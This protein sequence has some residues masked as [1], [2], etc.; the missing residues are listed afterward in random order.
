MALA[1]PIRVTA[2]ASGT[3]RWITMLLV[4]YVVAVMVAVSMFEISFLQDFTGRG[5][6]AQ[7]GQ[8]ARVAW[9]RPGIVF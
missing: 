2:R 5:Q 3:W 7:G 8:A 9:T 1:C 4:K 6:A